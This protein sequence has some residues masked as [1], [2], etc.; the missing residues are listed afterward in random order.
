[1]RSPRA[2]RTARGPE[3]SFPSLRGRN[4][5]RC[6][7]R[8]PRCMPSPPGWPQRLPRVEPVGARVS[9]THEEGSDGPRNVRRRQ[10]PPGEQDHRLGVVFLHVQ[11]AA[12]ME[13]DDPA[14]GSAGAI[15]RELLVVDRAGARHVEDPPARVMHALLEV[16]LLRVDEEVGVEVADAPGHL[17]PDEH[18]ARLDP[19]HLARRAVAAV[20]GSRGGGGAGAPGP[21]PLQA[22]KAPRTWDRVAV[23]DPGAGP[24]R[25]PRRGRAA[26]PR[27]AR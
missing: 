16:D 24:Q 18:R 17:A 11:V 13:L 1:M 4:V 14:P 10:Q 8:P 27:A 26:A 22:R 19:A 25:R 21:S 20:S 15:G 9:V 3:R 12:A 6:R 7:P 23:R 5:Q 2:T